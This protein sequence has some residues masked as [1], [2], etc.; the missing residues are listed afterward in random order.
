MADAGIVIAGGALDVSFT[1]SSEREQS[2]VLEALAEVERAIDARTEG[3]A[4]RLIQQT[5][6]DFPWRTD[7]NRKLVQM[8]QRIDVEVN[9]ALV[10]IS[11]VLEDSVK[12]P[13]S[14]TGTYLERICRESMARFSGLDPAKKAQ[15]II[16]Q[17][18]SENT[19]AEQ[20]LT[21]GKVELLLARAH[22][23]LGKN[24]FEIARFYFQSL[25]N[26]Y[27]DTPGAAVAIQELKLIHARGN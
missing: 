1:A 27:P 19:N 17:R 20:L 7:V 6:A 4:A 15:E 13:G 23:A 3:D 16:D 5:R 18:K 14:P 25:L 26:Q 2:R 10:Q 24:R 21:V 8:E 11:A 22:D 9:A 12:Y